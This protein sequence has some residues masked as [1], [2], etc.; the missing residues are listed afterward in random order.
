MD[1]K[2]NFYSIT[3][4]KQ[5]QEFHNIMPIENISSVIEYGILSHFNTVNL[6]HL[7][8]SMEEVQE[9]RDKITVPNGLALHKYANLYFHARNPMMYKRRNKNICILRVSKQVLTIPNIVIADR[10]ASSN[11]VNFLS[12]NESSRLNIPFIF[13]EDWNDS[14]ERYYYI[15]KSIKCV[16]VLIPNKVDYSYIIGAYVKNYNDKQKL[17]DSDFDKNIDIYKELFF[18]RG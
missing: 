5:V 8:I 3:T 18:Y 7:D 14:E 1:E 17:I 15:K 13:L 2:I 11:Y 10:N 16:E 4:F 9:R 12:I 6:S